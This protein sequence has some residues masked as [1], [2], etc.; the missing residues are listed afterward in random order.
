MRPEGLGK[1]KKFTSSGTRIHMQEGRTPQDEFPKKS[2]L[3]L[4]QAILLW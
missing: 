1:V 2:G 4:K 3:N